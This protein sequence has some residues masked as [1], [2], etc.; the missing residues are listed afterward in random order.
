MIIKT[1]NLYFNN[2]PKQFIIYAES[3][4]TQKSNNCSFEVNP[5][6]CA[7]TS[8]IVAGL[9]NKKITLVFAKIKN[10]KLRSREL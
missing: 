10:S 8:I 5:F 9:R 3:W 2:L 7:M 1:Y 6:D 4:N